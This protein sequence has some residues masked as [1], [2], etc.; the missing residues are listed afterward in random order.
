MFKVYKDVSVT[1]L[2]L[3]YTHQNAFIT[4][5]TVLNNNKY[6]L[7]VLMVFRLVFWKYKELLALT[8]RSQDCPH[9]SREVFVLHVV[10][11]R[12]GREAEVSSIQLNRWVRFL[13]DDEGVSWQRRDVVPA[14]DLYGFVQSLAVTLKQL[15]RVA[16]QSEYQT[17]KERGTGIRDGSRVALGL[18]FH[19]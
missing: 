11:W 14:G 12:L 9:R 13:E 4:F 1:L 19:V 3:N 8:L 17:E 15:R 2:L 18:H 6:V 16:S 10:V 7:C 5:C